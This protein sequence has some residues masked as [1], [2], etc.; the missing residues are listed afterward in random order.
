MHTCTHTETRRKTC[1]GR[2]LE[3]VEINTAVPCLIGLTPTPLSPPTTH[4]QPLQKAAEYKPDL[5]Q[6]KYYY[7]DKYEGKV[8]I[9]T[10]G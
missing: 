9:Q 4:T 8:S 6:E 7:N 5:K 2:L 1:Q 10:E 3:R